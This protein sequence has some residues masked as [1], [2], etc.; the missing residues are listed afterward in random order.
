M[1]LESLNVKLNFGLRKMGTGKHAFRLAKHIL[2]PAKL[3]VSY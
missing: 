3:K 2:Q 1:K